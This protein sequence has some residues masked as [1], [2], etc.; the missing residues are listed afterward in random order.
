MT[1]QRLKGVIDSHNTAHQYSVIVGPNG[2][3]YFAHN[4][5]HQA[6]ASLNIGTQITFL[7]KQ[8]TS[9]TYER[10]AFD[11]E[12]NGVKLEKKGIS[13]DVQRAAQEAL[14]LKRERQRSQT[15]DAR[16]VDRI[17]KKTANLPTQESRSEKNAAEVGFTTRIRMRSVNI[18]DFIRRMESDVYQTLTEEGIEA[19]NIY[20]FEA[21]SEPAIPPAAIKVDARVAEAFRA[22]S[23]IEKFYSHQVEARQFLLQGKNIVIST[24]TA[25]GKTEAYNPTILD[26]LLNNS[27]ATALYLFPLVALGLDQTER[28]EKLNKALPAKDQLKIGIYNGNIP[29]EKKEETKKAKNRI[30]VTTPDSLHYIFLPKNYENWRQFYRNLRYVVIDEAHVY[31]GVF[32]AN[33]AN[34]I[35]RLLA[36]CRREGNPQFPQVIISSAT[37]RHPEKL[38]QQLTGLP[39]ENFKVITESGAPRPARHFL[40]TRSDIHDIESLCSDLLNIKASNVERSGRKYVSTIVFMRSINEVKTSARNLREHL[41]RIGRSDEKQLVGEF[42]SDMGDKVDALDRL[43]NGDIRCLFTTTALMAGIDVGSLDVAIV[44]HFPGLIMDARQMFGRAG[45]SNEGAVIFIANR[46][47]PFDQFYFERSEQLFQGPVENVVANSE[48]PILLAAHLQ[49]AAQTEAQYNKEGPLSAQWADL[50]GQMGKDLLSILVKRGNMKMQTGNYYLISEADPHSLEPLN[51]LRSVGSETY[52]LKNVNNNQVLELKREATA[53]RDAHRE[54]IILVNGGNYKVVDFNKTTREIKCSP[55]NDSETRTR[56]V[57]ELT[58]TVVS[59]DSRD[60]H[61]ALLGGGATIASGEILITISVQSYVLYKSHMVMRCRSRACQYET[62][63]LE[64]RRCNTCGSPLRP[65]QVEEVVDEYSIPTPPTLE[66]KLKTRAV[67]VNFPAAMKEKLFNEFLPRWT[68]ETKKDET[69]IMPDFESALHSVKHAL[70]KA[71]PEYIPCDRDEIGGVYKV[72]KNPSARLFIY[73]NFQGGLG[74]SDEFIHEPQL[75]LEGALDLIERCTCIEDQG[76]P[77]CLSYFGCH[78]F[79]QK[80]SKLAGRYLLRV[81]LGQDTS[82]VLNDLKEYVEFNIPSAQRVYH[83]EVESLP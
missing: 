61:D 33:V 79:N 40:V 55:L 81:L 29:F 64:A 5:S 71:F 44:K 65:K 19:N 13:D 32:G 60:Q 18:G 42:Y 57:E 21:A 37:V 34:I 27:S 14:R 26:T 46:T 62:T 9:G 70:L 22:A 68:V 6:V 31:R 45:R 1:E 12:L 39:A 38:A 24:P 52:S 78:N 3:K 76:C 74:L 30:L 2:K 56:G 10:I 80:L 41:A 66:R 51:N 16:G 48:N 47:D 69:I 49:C 72:E 15:E 35:R 50:F 58:V 17:G 36:R 4:E 75:I 77:V 7:S 54:A 63:N 20:K 8:L 23:S 53:F 67:W 73:D 25:S 83:N 82:K 28:L 59:A 43:Q 11:I